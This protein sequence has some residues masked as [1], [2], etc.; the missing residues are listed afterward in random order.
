ALVCVILGTPTAA[1]EPGA[2]SVA[3]TVNGQN[4][5]GNT[6]TRPLPLDTNGPADVAVMIINRG[7]QPVEIRGIELSGRVL[8]L[9]FFSY[10]TA[11]DITV[12]PGST[13]T[14]NYRL[15]LTKLS[16][17]ATGL[18]AG[19]LTLR[20]G[21]GTAIATIATPTD[22]RGS[23][24]SVYGLFGIA[25]AT[26]TALALLDAAIAVARHRLSA[27][28]WRRGL[29]LLT[30]GIG[31]GLVLAFSTSIARVWL[32]DTATWLIAAAAAAAAFFAIGY[33]SPTP[34]DD[35]DAAE[36]DEFDD[37]DDVERVPAE[38]VMD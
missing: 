29:R 13:G 18:I 9:T 2:V 14:V 6:A 11:V 10:I 20:D 4:V 15:E 7:A 5:A 30:P 17:Q 21:A 24:L 37:D 16:G 34:D 38:Q 31:I 33:F 26:L 19:A 22:V 23:L 25:L 35:A 28:R 8:G 3:A 27:N 12:A 36:D 32:P 1:A